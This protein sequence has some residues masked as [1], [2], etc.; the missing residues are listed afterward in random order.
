MD[1]TVLPVRGRRMT[2]E[3]LALSQRIYRDDPHWV[4]PLTVSARRFMSPRQNPYFAEAEI[5]HFIAVDGG[6]T[7]LGRI[8]TTL[9]WAYIARYGKVGF[10]GWFECV[11]R[12]DVAT[13]LLGQA[14]RVARERGMTRLAGPYSYCSTQEFG[15][16]IDG[17]DTTPAAFQAHNPRY[18]ADLL[19]HAGYTIGYRTAT[20]MWSLPAD[21]AAMCDA[22]RR[23]ERAR[24]RHGLSVRPFDPRRWDE[25]MDMVFRLFHASFAANHDVTPMSRPVFDY[26]A[27]QVKAFLDP[28][29][30]R[31]VEKDGNAV[32]FSLLMADANEVLGPGRGRLSLGVLLRLAARRRI[33]HNA[34]VLMIGAHPQAVGL[35]VGRVLAGEIAKVGLGQV[36][37]YRRVHTTWIHQDNW[38]SRALVARSGTAPSRAYAVFEKDLVP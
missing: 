15:L 11:R 19:E 17:F 28:R 20:F 33:V 22:V 35:G 3:F 38:Q 23:G 21:E 37:A 6:G 16:L 29:L 12:R 31:F 26:Q 4:A 14:E 2:S 13:A 7:V 9:D 1:I 34:V 8:S 30:I 10:F 32:G 24:T 27:A 5:D 36:G 18:Y 25:E